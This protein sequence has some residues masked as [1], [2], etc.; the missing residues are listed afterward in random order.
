[1]PSPVRQS[2]AIMSAA[3]HQEN[4]EHSDYYEN[5]PDVNKGSVE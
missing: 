4:Y 5:T 1:M 2:R 3:S